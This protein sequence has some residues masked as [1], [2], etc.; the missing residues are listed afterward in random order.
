M[1]IALAQQQQQSDRRIEL[2]IAQLA[3]RDQATVITPA[4]TTAKSLA[5]QMVAFIYDPDNNLTF[6]SWYIRYQTI[7][8]T[9]VSDWPTA[10]KIRLL[11]Q[12]FSQADY[13]RFADSVLPQEPTQLTL[14]VAVEKLKRMFGY[15]ETKFAMRHKCFSLKTEDTKDFTT[16]AAR[17]NKHGEKFDVT[18]CTADDFKVLLFVSGLKN[19]QDSLIL[20]KLLAKIDATSVKLEAAT[21]DAGRAAIPKLTLQDLVNEAERLTSL[22]QD[23]SIVG[24]TITTPGSTEIN[25]VHKR[26]NYSRK[27]RGGRK[28]PTFDNRSLDGSGS[29]SNK[30]ASQP[31]S[32]CRYCGENHWEQECE[33]R[34]KKCTTC[35]V[36]GHKAGFCVSAFEAAVR[37]SRFDRKQR[38]TSDP[39]LKNNINQIMKGSNASQRKFV[40]PNI[41]GARVR[42]QIDSASDITIISKDNW[43]RLGKPTLKPCT[44]QPGSASG[45]SLRLWGSFQCTMSFIDKTETG[46]CYVSTRLN[47]L[48]IDWIEQL[49]LWNVPLASVCNAI[50]IDSSADDITSKAKSKFPQ[51]FADGLGLCTKTK[52]SLTLKPGTQ[53]IFRKQRPV[54]FAATTAVEEEIKR[55]QHLGVYKPVTFSEFAAPI[56]VVKKKNGK[57][58]ICGDY[59]TGL[60]DAL[61]PNKFPLPTPDQI[62]TALVG[63]CVFSKIDLPDA[64][65]QLELDDD[66]K[67]L[68]T[69]NTHLVLF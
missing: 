16:F 29:P 2:L 6:E 59:S 3:Q 57:T 66:A 69:I 39:G 62:F 65:L 1:Q 13:Q 40:S 41:N 45:H 67:K 64:F 20:E 22:K 23:K 14:N 30:N 37:R 53:K 26:N 35:S 47:L 56:V 44:I 8:T 51:L 28:S 18:H 50:T 43:E 32:P 36:I 49:G 25:A 7:F 10:A 60:N 33:Y 61:E 52:V 12:K 27:S 38:R 24:G 4:A 48:G 31:P 58:R 63:N 54:P 55:Q 5:E 9:E 17:I 19:P 15:R 42:L 34:D 68:L 46:T 21:D 11:L